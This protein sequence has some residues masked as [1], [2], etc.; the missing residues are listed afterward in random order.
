MFPGNNPGISPMGSIHLTLPDGSASS[1][2]NDCTMSRI[3]SFVGLS[4]AARASML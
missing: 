2:G 3:W 4:V 1:A